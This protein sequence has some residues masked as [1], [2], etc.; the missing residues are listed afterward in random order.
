MTAFNEGSGIA[1]INWLTTGRPKPSDSEFAKQE[2]Y[3]ISDGAFTVDD[4]VDQLDKFYGVSANRDVPVAHAVLFV[5][6]KF[7]GATPQELEIYAQQLRKMAAD[8]S[9][10]VPPPVKVR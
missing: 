3:Y 2:S 6:L 5:I 8:K 1:I 10:H 9:G 4:T 7:R